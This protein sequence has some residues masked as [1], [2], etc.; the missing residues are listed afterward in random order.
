VYADIEL[1]NG[2]D[3]VLL[4]LGQ[5]AEPDVRRVSVRAH[6]DS[7]ADL[8][9]INEQINGQ[10]QLRERGR[11]PATL[12]DGP[13]ADLALVGPLEV[14]FENRRANVDA[15][16]LPGDAEVLLGAIPREYMDV[17]V[18]PRR[19]RLIVNPEHPYRAQVRLA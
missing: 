6:V 10:L 16:V 8:M 13:I 17:L 11:V 18:D 7:G 19:R 9:C 3:R 1:V 12:A 4:E 14:I 5:L 15:L 2:A